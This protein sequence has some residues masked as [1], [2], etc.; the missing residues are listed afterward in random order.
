MPKGN[1]KRVVAIVTEYRFNSHADVIL[2]RL[3]GDMNYS[4]SIEVVSIYTDQVPEN[5][6]SRTEAMRCGIPIYSTI[7]EAIETAY[8][9]GGLDGVI[10]IAEHGDYLKDEQ[11]RIHY[12]R[13]RMLE[14][15]LRALDKLEIQVPIF[16]DKHFSYQIEDTVWVYQQVKNRGIPFMAGSSIPHTPHIPAIEL[17]QLQASNEWLVLSF[18]TLVEA[19]GYHALEVLQS[20]AEH[21]AGG[22]T[23]IASISTLEGAAVWEAMARGEWPEDLLINCLKQANGAA[24]KHPSELNEPTFLITVEYLDGTKGY[25]FQQEKLTDFWSFS[26]RN[27][28][29]V[30]TAKCDSNDERPFKHFDRLTQLIEQFIITGEEQFPIERVFLS[31]GMINYAVE[32]LFQGRRLQTPELHIHYS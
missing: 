24:F 27:K 6:M 28:Q 26:V 16:S 31:S 15:V 17:K 18:S 5:D 3:L 2:G 4:P 11:G 19:Y 9:E 7:E 10:I 1:A 13:R 22:E 14:A 23:G 30:F 21:R 29:G 12:P 32:S 25:V 20:V 8:A